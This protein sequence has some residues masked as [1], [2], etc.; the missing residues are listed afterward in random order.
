MVK[1]AELYQLY[2]TK[3]KERGKKGMLE[4][5]DD[6]VLFEHTVEVLGNVPHLVHAG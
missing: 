5:D 2:V 4:R 3:W 1:D 6:K